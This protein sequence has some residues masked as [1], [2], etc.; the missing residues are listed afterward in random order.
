M[1][2]APFA[3]CTNNFPDFSTISRD[4]FSGPYSPIR[5]RHVGGTSRGLSPGKANAVVCAKS[6]AAKSERAKTTRRAEGA[7]RQ[8]LHALWRV[9]ICLIE[10]AD[11]ISDLRL[12]RELECEP[13]RPGKPLAGIPAKAFALLFGDFFQQGEGL[14]AAILCAGGENGV[15]Q[16]NGSDIGS[17]EGGGFGGGDEEFMAFVG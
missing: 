16:R 11:M 8:M 10:I 13:R 4:A 17:A 9:E 12:I 5:F 7:K 1:V 3:S 2:S 15:E 14:R 6:E